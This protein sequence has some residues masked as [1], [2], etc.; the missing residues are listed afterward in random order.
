LLIGLLAI[1]I[2]VWAVSRSASG[3]PVKN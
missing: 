2:A 3:E 1:G